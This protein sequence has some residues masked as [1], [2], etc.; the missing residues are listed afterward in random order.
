MAG[1]FTV[2]R[3][4]QVHEWHTGEPLPEPI[5]TARHIFAQF[6]GDELNFFL[7]AISNPDPGWIPIETGIIPNPDP[8]EDNLMSAEILLFVPDL[9][10]D[11]VVIG[12]YL[13]TSKRFRNE[14]A[15]SAPATHWRHKP[16]PP[17]NSR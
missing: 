10:N 11:P 9:A 7:R 3:I 6:D 13:F 2:D 14:I 12:R 4:T 15:K 8:R 16:K 17:G 1:F 5:K